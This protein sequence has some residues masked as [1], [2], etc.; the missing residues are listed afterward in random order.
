MYLWVGISPTTSFYDMNIPDNFCVE[1]IVQ[2]MVMDRLDA[3]YNFS[4]VIASSE[5]ARLLVQPNKII[6][7]DSDCRS[8]MF[9]YT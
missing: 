7:P 6:I 4:S 8:T 2:L 9:H 3:F 1:V 5:N